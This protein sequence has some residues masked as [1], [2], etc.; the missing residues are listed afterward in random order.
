MPR[1]D[2]FAFKNSGLNEFLFAEVGNEVNGSPLTILSV[3]AR[4]GKDPW[5]EAA[6]LARL[7]KAAIIDYLVGGISQMPLCPQ[8]LSNARSTAA[9]VI[10]LLP[11][12]TP[13]LRT[14]GETMSIG[15]TTIPGW[16]PLAVLFAAVA[17]VIAFEM[18][19]P[20]APISTFAPLVEPPAVHP[21][22]P[23]N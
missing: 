3:L 11:S 5:I 16:V 22:A 2:A 23:A 6:R 13:S 7:P 18:I 4:L 9:R 10:L 20:A 17:G 19:P 8:A 15:K 14:G 1:S 21:P 12:Q